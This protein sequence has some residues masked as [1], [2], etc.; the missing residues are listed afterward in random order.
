MKKLP[1]LLL[2]AAL[3]VGTAPA[4]GQET[5]PGIAKYVFFFIGDGM[6]NPQTT[7]A[8]YYNGTMEN[9]E[10]EVPVS[11]G[12]SFTG[13]PVVGL[14]VTHDASSFAPDSAATATAMATGQKTTSGTVNLLPDEETPL[15]IITEYAREA[16]MKIG[17][18]TSV[19]LDHATPA[20]QYA[21][22][23]HRSNQYDIAVQ[24]LTNGL[25][26]FLGGGGFRQTDG[27]RGDKRNLFEIARENGW[28]LVN[29]NEGI[30]AIG[31]S[32][33]RTLAIVPD[34]AGGDAMQYEVDRLAIIEDGGDSLSLKE[35]TS[36][37]IRALE[38]GENGFFLMAEGGKIDWAAHAN[39]V[40]TMI[41]E[42][43]AL[44]EAVGAALD[45]SQ[46]H[47]GET[48]IVVT[49]DHE[50]GG[51]SLGYAATG[52]DIDLELLRRQTMS[53][54]AFDRVVAD[55]RAK[56]A[57]FDEVLKA[58][59]RNFGLTLDEERSLRLTDGELQKLEDAYAM[60]LLPSDERDYGEEE[61]INYGDYQPLSVT[62][63][64]ILARKAGL[65]F[66]SYAHTGL[67][68]P[69]YAWGAGAEY[70]SGLYDNTRI[71]HHF[72]DAMGLTPDD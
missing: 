43:N 21:R 41:H 39:D 25:L 67:T 54:E 36:A 50:T 38:G 24:G 64:H 6:S 45:F 69:V 42:V 62:A 72:M 49:G 46:K 5:A 17:V 51:L 34:L 44:D 52:Y 19:S 28:N 40:F 33:G 10:S 4:L 14:Q 20:A 13:F 22:S 15:K 8:Q 3:L 60:N 55:L 27:R 2:A 23:S 11:K 7:A 16:G 68:L 53:F 37:A 48:L 70:F 9:R 1:A 71:F 47:P 65:N 56:E 59:T 61:K 30:R 35:M 63:V 31:A 29:D 58:I 12:L 66:S 18:V 57:G 32:S 26:D